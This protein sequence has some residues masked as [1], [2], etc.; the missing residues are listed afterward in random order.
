MKYFFRKFIS[1]INQMSINHIELM[2]DRIIDHLKAKIY[3][4]NDED[5]EHYLYDVIHEEIDNYVSTNSIQENID[6]MVDIYDAMVAYKDTY[7]D[8]DFKNKAQFYACLAYHKLDEEIR[9]NHID[10]IKEDL[11]EYFDDN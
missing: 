7:G 4:I 5:E 8:V 1:K 6:I 9:E 2:V 10:R 3:N 11:A